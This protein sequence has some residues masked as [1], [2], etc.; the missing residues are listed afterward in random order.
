[1]TKFETIWKE[2]RLYT[3]FNYSKYNDY[4]L[5]YNIFMA[6]LEAVAKKHK[7]DDFDSQGFDFFLKSWRWNAQQLQLK[8]C[9]DRTITAKQF[10]KE[11]YEAYTPEVYEKETEVIYIKINDRVENI[12][13]INQLYGVI[14]Y[15][16]GSEIDSDTLSNEDIARMLKRQAE[17]DYNRYEHLLDVYKEFI[18]VN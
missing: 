16:D 11:V 10:C 3:Y 6:E 7:G 17:D 13:E 1:M 5:I 4:V 14:D 15:E 18:I 2:L 8:S 9:S 12:K